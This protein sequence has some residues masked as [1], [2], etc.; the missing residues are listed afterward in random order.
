MKPANTVR[1]CRRNDRQLITD[2][3]SW[4]TSEKYRPP[5]YH[6]ND[7]PKIFSILISQSLKLDHLE[8]LSSKFYNLLRQ[9]RNLHVFINNVNRTCDRTSFWC[10]RHVADGLTVSRHTCFYPNRGN[11]QFALQSKDVKGH[12]L[13]KD[14]AA[15]LSTGKI[16]S[17]TPGGAA[18][19]AAFSTSLFTTSLSTTMIQR[20][21]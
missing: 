11:G 6:N 1:T 19:S 20:L 9:F 21:V 2:L 10:L 13:Q 12:L 8:H 7:L 17:F 14:T 3:I 5:L 16:L 4:S 15:A 18:S